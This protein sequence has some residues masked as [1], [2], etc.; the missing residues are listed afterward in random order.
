MVSEET[1]VDIIV[2][3][4]VTLICGVLVGTFGGPYIDA[5]MK[6][7]GSLIMWATGEQPFIMGII[8]SVVMGL[9]LTSPLSSAALGIMLDLSGLAAGAAAVGCTAQ[10]LSLIH[11]S[12]VEAGFA[13]SKRDFVMAKPAS[14]CARRIVLARSGYASK[15]L[16]WT[17]ASRPFT[18]TRL[19]FCST[20]CL[21]RRFFVAKP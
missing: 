18:G 10:M 5:L 20:C 11:I 2:T 9:A 7:R 12:Q 14:T 19:P 1:K 8:I 17:G 6:G 15:G 4:A 16:L 3:Q 21:V 13:K